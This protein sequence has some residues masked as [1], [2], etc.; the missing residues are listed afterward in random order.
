M[1]LQLFNHYRVCINNGQ[2][3][4]P[5]SG[6]WE[7]AD[8]FQSIDVWLNIFGVALKTVFFSS[9]EFNRSYFGLFLLV[10]IM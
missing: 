2:C 6:W 8:A 10:P 1:A 3:I 5:T 9:I 4:F 7:K